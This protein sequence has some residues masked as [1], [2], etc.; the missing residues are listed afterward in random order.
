MDLAHHTRVVAGAMPRFR[1]PAGEPVLIP[2]SVFDRETASSRYADLAEGDAGR[3][4]ESDGY[5][6]FLDYRD[7]RSPLPSKFQWVP[8]AGSEP[9][10]SRQTPWVAGSR[11]RGR[12]S[13]GDVGGFATQVSAEGNDRGVRPPPGWRLQSPGEFSYHQYPLLPSPTRAKRMRHR[14]GGDGGGGANG[15]PTP[16]TAVGSSRASPHGDVPSWAGPPP[17][18]AS[19]GGEGE[20]YRRAGSLPSALAPPQRGGG[21][22]R[23]ALLPP[24][25]ERGAAA[26]GAPFSSLTAR[27]PASHAAADSAEAMTR[28]GPPPSWRFRSRE[29]IAGE[30]GASLAG[31]GAAR[32]LELSRGRRSSTGDPPSGAEVYA[33]FHHRG[34]RQ[35]YLVDRRQRS[36]PPIR[37]QRHPHQSP[38][39]QRD[40]Q[41]QDQRSQPRPTFPP[42]G[43][44]LAPP[45]LDRGV[46]DPGTYGTV[47]R[48]LLSPPPRVSEPV[49]PPYPLSGLAETVVDVGGRPAG[50][51]RSLVFREASEDLAGD[52]GRPVRG[53]TTTTADAGVDAEEGSTKQQ[54]RYPEI[55]SSS[56]FSSLVFSLNECVMVDRCSC[57]LDFPLE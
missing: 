29:R 28:P 5:A 10:L 14:V 55:L 25:A 45:T 56:V 27:N 51:G 52:S 23:A 19:G 39:Q 46:S 26:V 9:V 35:F 54:Q 33:G 50:S 44:T 42:A 49:C 34:G 6:R 22:R 48:P 3:G 32:L 13:P 24:T 21:Y 12:R 41:Q 8:Y 40:H 43:A 53:N 36:S 16:G 37:D 47:F 11:G 38:Q 57:L 20:R 15:L 7:P 4:G 17:L 31:G 18:P 2:S 30:E 1:R